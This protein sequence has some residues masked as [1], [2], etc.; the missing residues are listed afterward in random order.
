MIFV[1]V[2][3]PLWDLGHRYGD[4]KL[5]RAIDDIL[6]NEEQT[7]KERKADLAAIIKSNSRGEMSARNYL[8]EGIIIE[9]ILPSNPAPETRKT[10]SFI[11]ALKMLNYTRDKNRN[12]TFSNGDIEVIINGNTVFARAL[13][14]KDFII[15]NYLLFYIH[16]CFQTFLY[17]EFEP[18]K[19]NE[20]DPV[21]MEI[22]M[23]MLPYIDIFL[24]CDKK[25]AALLKRFKDFIGSNIVNCEIDYRPKA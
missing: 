1:A 8:M 12:N 22:G 4:H 10:K 13:Q 6:K 15:N 16:I 5:S 11:L 18:S 19:K 9:I 20:N 25:Q 2:C 21:D 17:N 3:V 7:S 14:R 24:T 23:F